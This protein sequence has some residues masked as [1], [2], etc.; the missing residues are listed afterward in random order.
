MGV[1]TTFSD[2]S[3]DS[4]VHSA[5][6]VV[7]TDSSNSTDGT[8]SSV[9]TG[10][11]AR[12]RLP[13]DTRDDRLRKS[14]VFLLSTFLGC[15][16]LLFILVGAASGIFQSFEFVLLGLLAVVSLTSSF[17]LWRSRKVRYALLYAHFVLVLLGVLF[18]ASA[19]WVAGIGIVDSNGEPKRYHF[20]VIMT[21]PA[22]AAFTLRDKRFILMYTS[23]SAFIAVVLSIA[24]PEGDDTRG[25]VAMLA[26]TVLI[27]LITGFAFA[28][29]QSVS[30]GLSE[31]NVLAKGK[32]KVAA[33]EAKAER[34]ANEAKSR[35]VSV[36]SHEIRNP[37][38][39]ILLQL[40]LLEGTGL[41]DTQG[42]Y[43][44]GITRASHVLLT[45]V[46]DILDVTKIESGAIALESINM[47]LRDV[48]EFTLHTNAP[49]AA[50]QG[51]ELICNIEP[52][53]NT[54]VQG[55]PTRVR[56][57]LHNLVSNAL[58]FTTTGEVEVTL[59]LVDSVVELGEQ[60]VEVAAE[61]ATDVEAARSSRRRS[62]WSLTVRDTGIGI[63]DEGKLKLFREFSQVDETTTRMYGGTGLGLFICKE[64]SEIMGGH[65]SV[66]S[67]VGIGSTFTATFL[68][69][70]SAEEDEQAVHIVSSDVKWTVV[71]YATNG[72][73]TRVLR[74]Y[75]EFFFSG[76][77]TVKY[78]VLDRPKIAEQ[79][80]RAM[81]DD[82]SAGHRL[83]V[84]VNHVDCTASLTSL[85]TSND[86]GSCVPVV[87][88]DDPIASVR[89]EL[90]V[91]GWR[92]VVHKPVSLRQL[93]STLDRAIAGPPTKGDAV[94]SRPKGAAAGGGFSS[95]VRTLRDGTLTRGMRIP[96]H[97][98]IAEVSAAHA[99]EHPDSSIILIVDD[100]ELVRSLVQQVIIQIGYN[101]LVAANGK[102]AAELVRANYKDIAMVLMDC[103]MPIMDGY[104]AT[105]AIRSY[106][107]ETGIPQSKELFICAMTANAMRED[108]KKCYA[109]RMSGFLA[110]PVKRADV[111]QVLNEHARLPGQRGPPS[112]GTSKRKKNKKVA[113]PAP[114]GAVKVQSP[115]ISSSPSRRKRRGN[116]AVDADSSL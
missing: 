21:V 64:L 106:E 45:I 38:Q 15:A 63:D 52:T 78:I 2:T 58:K 105:E 62:R 102:E 82:C 89:K 94:A 11:D 84:C 39:A 5:P 48:V 19:P 95:E 40:E 91:E 77:S 33:R 87:L 44:A 109:R 56:Q 16:V 74:T 37:L 113:E 10:L 9:L 20:M 100:F 42:D 112:G 8:S 25:M 90:G 107:S 4:G 7:P 104:E 70:E 73:L 27:Q 61:T 80:I 53:L 22:I 115:S 47:S 110:K 98:E 18:P 43:V 29:F 26:S 6:G 116:A 14:A 75:L 76:V 30:D 68:C 36:M 101:T 23:V 28:F 83:V 34:R 85:L 66:E 55:D 79:R 93:C 65:V 111:E 3:S 1:L 71:L 96:D 88:S 103:E 67:E 24:N 32:A 54:Q 114:D 46:N 97:L 99:A 50:K 31:E 35:F 49:K 57:I 12:L 69:D 81:L 108:V 41:S 17:F 86:N 72:A 51:V 13:G 59:A 92:S 60:H